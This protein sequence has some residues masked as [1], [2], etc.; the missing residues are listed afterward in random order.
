ML[1]RSKVYELV[2]L[3]GIRAVLQIVPKITFMHLVDES[4]LRRAKA[5]KLG[6]GMKN[7]KRNSNM[8]VVF[9]DS[10]LRNFQFKFDDKL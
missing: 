6:E 1:L 5:R 7:G 9:L 4:S 8:S 10:I 2:H 3:P